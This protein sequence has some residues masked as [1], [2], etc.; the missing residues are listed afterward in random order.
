MEGYAPEN[1]QALINQALN[2][3]WPA[4]RFYECLDEATKRRLA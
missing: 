4:D 3:K 2:E 1:I